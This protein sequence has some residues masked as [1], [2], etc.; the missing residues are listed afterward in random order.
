MLT[1][2]LLHDFLQEKKIVLEL[3]C[4]IHSFLD[5]AEM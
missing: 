1:V 3:G 4:C 5:S 2:G